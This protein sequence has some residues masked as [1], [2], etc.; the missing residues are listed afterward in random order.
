VIV[1]R[2]HGADVSAP[3]VIGVRN[4]GFGA[5]RLALASSVIV[6]HGFELL[7]GDAGRE[8]LTSLF[9][10][11]TL[12]T[13]AVL[14]F[15]VISGYLVAGS[16]AT[17]PGTYFSKRVLRIYPAFIVASLLCTLVVAPIGGAALRELSVTDWAKAAART[18]MLQSPTVPGAFEDLPEHALNGSM[19]TISYEF[20]CYILAAVFG[21]VGLY[22]RPRLFVV[23][24][25][26]MLAANLLFVVPHVRAALQ[27][28]GPV[29][30]VVG[31]PRLMVRLLSAFMMG[32]CFWL[33]RPAIRGRV[34]LAA[35]IA[36]PMV[37]LAKDLHTVAVIVLGGYLLFWLAFRCQ[38][39]PLR[40]INARNDISYGVYLYAFPI[41]QLLILFW[42][43]IPVTAL[44]AA[45][46]V[47]AIVCGALSWWSIEKPALALRRRLPPLT[48]R[49]RTRAPSSPHA[50]GAPGSST[51]IA[52]TEP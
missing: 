14:G 24:T 37:M 11:M 48:T 42:R 1:S 36:L 34:A 16:F 8:P 50:D 41:A 46:F 12:G 18:L 15:F 45:T 38:W 9:G 2:P 6:S 44:I 3:A 33:L 35:A 22:L 28:P 49:R 43:E 40:Q 31:Q 20:R 17:D 25:S 4:N 47:L 23:L 10:G 51:A 7:D 26:L 19:W 52:V 29:A 5:L 27:F 21:L 39:R 13:A 32:T 30:L